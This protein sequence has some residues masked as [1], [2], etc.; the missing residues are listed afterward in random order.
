MF[1][2]ARRQAAETLNRVFGTVE[3]GRQIV[4]KK[5]GAVPQNQ[6]PILKACCGED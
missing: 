6:T 3:I 1:E 5:S 4:A 2:G